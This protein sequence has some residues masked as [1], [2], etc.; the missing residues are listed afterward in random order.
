MMWRE[1]GLAEL[2]AYLPHVSANTNAIENIKPETIVN[3][4]YGDSIGRGAFKWTPGAW[5]TVAQRV[6]MND[7]GKANAEVEI[8]FNG[9]SVINIKGLE[10]CTFSSSTFRG[11]MYQCF[12]GGMCSFIFS[13]LVV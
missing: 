13:L 11:V 7:V 2:Y 1:N 10:L 12:F 3:P 4:D 5:G 9:K 6:K 8:Y